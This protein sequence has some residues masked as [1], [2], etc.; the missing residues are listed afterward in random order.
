MLRNWL[1][2][3]IA[4]VLLVALV[5]TV[6]LG[7]R[8]LREV[9]ALPTA[10]VPLI[11]TQA[12][13]TFA[14]SLTSTAVAIPSNTP[15]LTPPPMTEAPAVTEGTAEG[16]S[17]VSPTP[18]CYR[19]KYDQDVTIPDN[20][21][22]TPAQVFTKTWQVENN[23]TCAWKPGFR[24]VLVGG[25]AMGGS[26]FVLD[27]TVN[28]GGRIQ[29]SIKMV[30]PTNQTGLIQGTWRMQDDTGTPFGDALTVVIVIGGP[31]LSS[32]VTATATSTP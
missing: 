30:A 6:V 18:S 3:A 14:F 4:A 23:G 15:T 13:G 27:S 32:S 24:M 1:P 21:L 26:P 12:V 5:F 17:S 29:I 22:M 7:G 8:A 9:A 31:T 10:D 2:W 25:T 11:Q 19:L 16:T 28:P 20:T